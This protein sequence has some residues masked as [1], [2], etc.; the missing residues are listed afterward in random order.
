MGGD[1]DQVS[2][3]VLGSIVQTPEG[4]PAAAPVQPAPAS[5]P[6]SAGTSRESSC[7]LQAASLEASDEFILDGINRLVSLWIRF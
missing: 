2:D 6:P 1:S 3:Q 7:V 4:G 5:A